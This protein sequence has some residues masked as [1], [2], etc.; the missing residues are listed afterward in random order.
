MCQGLDNLGVARGQSKAGRA[1]RLRHIRGN[2]SFAMALNLG[3]Y[4]GLPLC[5]MKS[6]LVA[7]RFGG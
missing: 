3:K 5:F 4:S 1:G 2:Y 7:A 6:L